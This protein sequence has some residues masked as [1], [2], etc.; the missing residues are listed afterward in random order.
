[1]N[2]SLREIDTWFLARRAVLIT[3][4]SIASIFFGIGIL[5][6]LAEAL[7]FEY[8]AELANSSFTTRRII[9]FHLFLSELWFIFIG[10]VLL[11]LMIGNRNFVIPR[12]LVIASR[13]VFLVLGVYSL[14]FVYGSLAGNIWALQ[15]FREMVF[16]A[17]SLPPI[18]YF[19][20]LLSARQAFEKFIIPGA[21]LLLALSIF[22]PPNA[23]LILATFF[24][25]YFALK[26]LYKSYWAI[27]GLGLASLPF[28]FQLPTLKLPA[29]PGL[30]SLPF[31]FQLP[32]LKLPAVP[33]P[34]NES[35]PFQLPMLRL[36]A[37]PV[38]SLVPTPVASLPFRLPTF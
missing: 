18:L 24:V 4:S 31:P 19:A 5:L 37:M 13:P 25:S 16:T 35:F 38:P 17:L 20:S 11:F 22:G 15:E 23:A 30:A 7:F 33:L 3:S 8:F 12:H 1:M 6:I 28:P 36:P 29:M 32:T 14:W 26:L 27:V 10:N 9:G 2:I 34:L 21:L